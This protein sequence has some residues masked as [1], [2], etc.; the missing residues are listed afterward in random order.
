MLEK[1][2]G[3]YQKYLG[4][5]QASPI[6]PVVLNMNDAYDTLTIRIGDVVKIEMTK[7]EFDEKTV[8]EIL[9]AA[10]VMTDDYH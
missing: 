10:G 4:L 7:E 8:S 1:D 5:V 2:R 6:K 3:F 9:D